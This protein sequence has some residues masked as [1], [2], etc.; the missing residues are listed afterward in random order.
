[1]L[2]VILVG[3][4]TLKRNDRRGQFASYD[5]LSIRAVMYWYPFARAGDA[6]RFADGLA[7]AGVPE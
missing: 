4:E 2:E 7:K 6:R 5:P 3:I 1:M